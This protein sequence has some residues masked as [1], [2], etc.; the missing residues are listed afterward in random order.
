MEKRRHESFKVFSCLKNM[1]PR[2]FRN[3]FER[4]FS[5]KVR[6]VGE[7]TEITP[8]IKFLSAS[9]LPVNM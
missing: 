4:L 5:K 6:K 7:N 9:T 2:F 8:I 1:N 3:Q